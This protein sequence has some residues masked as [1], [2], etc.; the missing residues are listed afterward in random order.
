MILKN[1]V[2]AWEGCRKYGKGFYGDF[3]GL[4]FLPRF[5]EE[6]SMMIMLMTFSPRRGA[7]RK[8]RRYRKKC[9]G[10][11]YLAQRLSV[12]DF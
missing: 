10:G 8:F 11:W 2:I 9:V 4:Y 1:G 7:I 5:F 3:S 12:F 6:K